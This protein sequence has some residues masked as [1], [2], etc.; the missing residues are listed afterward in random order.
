MF[1]IGRIFVLRSRS[2][3]V[4]LGII[5]LLIACWSAEASAG[6]GLYT[7]QV[8]VGSQ[9]D[10]ERTEA[11]KTALAQVVI[12]VCGDSGALAKADV[13][14]AVADAERYVQQFSYQQDIVAEG[15]QPQV[16]LT[17]V[18]QFDRDAV[19]QLLRNLG[20]LKDT[21]LP[22]GQA[23]P[24]DATPGSYRVW[25]AGVRSPQDYARLIGALSGNEFVRDVQV[26]LARGDGV[27]IRLTTAASLSRL[28]D[29]L[30][31][32]AV[33]RVAKARPP[34]DGLDALLDLQP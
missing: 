1:P 3:A 31:A 34:V 33:I 15:G 20:L 28:L 12:R 30:S 14:K 6:S 23:A 17:L 2:A 27:Q 13:A 29:N 26:E 10:A 8:P 22:E 7:G 9:S 5:A 11:L 25:V 4:C 21:A 24:V 16:R 19:D 32:S 18:A